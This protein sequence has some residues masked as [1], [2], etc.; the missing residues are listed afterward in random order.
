MLRLFGV[1]DGLAFVVEVEN[2][3]LDQSKLMSLYA[4]K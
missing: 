2:S 4:P 1:S 3:G